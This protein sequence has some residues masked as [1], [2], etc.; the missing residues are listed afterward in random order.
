MYETTR[1]AVERARA[2]AGPTIIE[3]MT[4]RLGGHNRRDPCNYM[5]KDERER[6]LQQ[7]PVKR[8]EEVLL[9]DGHAEA[10]LLAEMQTKLETE[11]EAVVETAL[12][13]PDPDPE[14]AFRYVYAESPES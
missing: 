12:A 14:E 1:T 13:A 11:I 8:F 7:E 9:R 5:P 10:S 2:G 3:A 4:Y 6:A